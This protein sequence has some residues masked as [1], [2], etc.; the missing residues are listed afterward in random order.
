MVCR[1]LLA[2][3]QAPFRPSMILRQWGRDLRGWSKSTD[4]FRFGIHG[5]L[6]LGPAFV[7]PPQIHVPSAVCLND[8]VHAFGIHALPE[9][10]SRPSMFNWSR[11][12]GQGHLGWLKWRSPHDHACTPTCPFKVSSASS[13][14][15]SSG[16]C[17]ANDSGSQ[18]RIHERWPPFLELPTP[19][20]WSWATDASPCSEKRPMMSD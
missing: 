18:R 20:T 12:P 19:A 10:E 7:F 13:M 8:E 17:H 3:S 4:G 11:S 1:G 15:N 14:S 5:P 6:S 9:A 16:S 2:M